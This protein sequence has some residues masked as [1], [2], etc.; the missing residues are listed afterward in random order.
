MTLFHLQQRTKFCMSWGTSFYHAKGHE[1]DFGSLYQCLQTTRITI[2][3]S[4]LYT[5]S[6]HVYPFCERFLK[7]CSSW[8]PNLNNCRN[9]QSV[10]LSCGCSGSASSFGPR[11]V[12]SCLFAMGGAQA[13]KEARLVTKIDLAWED[14]RFASSHSAVMSRPASPGI[15]KKT[16]YIYI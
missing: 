9:N 10:D 16:T 7:L 11:F 14:G 1:P 2:Q 13:A 5:I 8:F 6:I 4:P 3:H 15:F 12:C